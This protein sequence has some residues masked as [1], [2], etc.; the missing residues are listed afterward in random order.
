MARVLLIVSP[1]TQ[2]FDAQHEQRSFEYNDIDPVSL[3]MVVAAVTA[4]SAD[5]EMLYYFAFCVYFYV[6]A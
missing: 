1:A 6:G 2:V 4:V 3:A 5:S